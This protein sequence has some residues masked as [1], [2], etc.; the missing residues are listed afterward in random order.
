MSK[1]RKPSNWLGRFLHWVFGSEFEQLPSEFGDP[2][3]PDLE[4]FERKA[5]EAQHHSVA[6]VP[7]NG[8]G[9]RHAEHHR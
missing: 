5:E 7:L 4:A 1:N 8:T 6:S 2:I 3:P 9:H